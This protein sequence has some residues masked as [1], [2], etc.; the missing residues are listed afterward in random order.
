MNLTHLFIFYTPKKLYH[1]LK[2]LTKPIQRVFDMI[3]PEHYFHPSHIRSVDPIF[4]LD[5]KIPTS[6]PYYEGHFPDNP[7]LPAVAIIDFSL[8]ALEKI[9]NTRYSLR[10]IQSAKFKKP[11]FPGS[12]I[13]IQIEA[14]QPETYKITWTEEQS[15]VVEMKIEVC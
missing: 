4:E 12:N 5:F 2:L 11:I 14:L 1:L 6:L 8:I 9:F 3:N 15:K 13:S 10:K 7:V